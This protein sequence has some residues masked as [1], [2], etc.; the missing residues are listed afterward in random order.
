MPIRQ[1]MRQGQKGCFLIKYMETEWLRYSCQM[2]LPGFDTQG[3]LA[4]QNSRVLIVGAG[5]LG[6]P[7]A[8]YLVGAG[9]GHIAIADDDIVSTS[10][11]HRQ[12]LFT[13]ADV[14]LP[15][16]IIACRKLQEQ[17]PLITLVPVL[18]R[19]TLQNVMQLVAPYDIILDATDNFEA[20]YLLNDSCVILD[21]PLVYGAIYQFEGQV[22]VWN[23]KNGDNSRSVNYRDLYP[24]SNDDWIPDCA[25]GGVLPTLGGIIGS[26]QAT[27]VL[28]YITGKGELLKN[29][30]LIVD[31]F[32]Y[33]LQVIGLGRQT[34]TS[35]THLDE[36]NTVQ[37]ITPVQ[38]KE[39]LQDR[40]VQLID[41]RDYAEH[42][43]GNLGGNNI[44]LKELASYTIDNE[45]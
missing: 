17:N 5:G 16:A 1:K 10:N 12:I 4:L 28:K 27:E 37:T 42:R 3:Q 36:S 2:K 13:P 44:T 22:A 23:L 40:S 9:V 38:L 41:V 31:V 14:G 32:D 20:K 18:E 26:L 21:K 34:H 11:L 15:K 35:I 29:K 8:Q 19:V 45:N 25:E 39:K 7:A 30:L 24:R 33:R 43:A 6:C